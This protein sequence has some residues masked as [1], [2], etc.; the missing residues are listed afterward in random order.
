MFLKHLLEQRDAG[1]RY[2]LGVFPENV[3]LLLTTRVVEPQPGHAGRTAVS[4]TVGRGFPA[5]G[6][7]LGGRSHQARW[8][9]PGKDQRAPERGCAATLKGELERTEFC[10]RRTERLLWH[11][12]A[13]TL[14]QGSAT[15]SSHLRQ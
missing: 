6:R 4:G 13:R 15:P 3:R 8:V 1:C 2:I 14:G 12:P 11:P 10:D 9:I 5:A 7:G